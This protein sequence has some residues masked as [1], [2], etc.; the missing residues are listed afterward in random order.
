MNNDLLNHKVLVIEDDEELNE[1]IVIRLKRYFKNVYSSLNAED[2]YNIY[3]KEKSDIMFVDIELPKMNGLE[4][5]D[6]IRQKDQNVKVVILTAQSDIDLLLKSTGLKLTK[7][8]LKPLTRADLEETIS[9][10]LKE[11]NSFKI[12]HNESINFQENFSWNKQKNEL[13]KNGDIVNLTP[14]ENEIFKALVDNPNRIL[15]NDELILATYGDYDDT[16][17]EALKTTLKNLRKKLPKDLIQNVFA[18]GYKL[19][20]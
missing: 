14:K 20:Y 2:G 18:Q 10:L 13:L 17:K 1:K 5:L 16:K 8:L 6:I 7:Y 4:L 11:I 15:S 3:L 9:L 19:V 12:I